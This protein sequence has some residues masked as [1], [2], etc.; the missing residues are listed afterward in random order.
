[1]I[2]HR[3]LYRKE[4][5]EEE[6]I[7]CEAIYYDAWIEENASLYCHTVAP[8][9]IRF[10][11]DKRIDTWYMVKRSDTDVSEECPICCEHNEPPEFPDGEFGP[12]FSKYN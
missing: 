11:V 9:N 7:F 5:G 12:A 3:H 4:E 10:Y 1:M 8:G 6:F 2:P